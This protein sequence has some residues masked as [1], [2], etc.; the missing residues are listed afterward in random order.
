MTKAI[1]YLLI[2]VISGILVLIYTSK[3]SGADQRLIELDRKHNHQLDS[4]T[5][6][7]RDSLHKRE[8]AALKAFSD[9]TRAKNKAEVEANHW[10]QKYE[11][12][13]NTNRHF[14]DHAIDSLLAEVR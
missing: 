7:Y 11:N 10:K 5:S 9:A 4:I 3:P 12:E 13:K 2:F 1:T 8:L 14:S 6:V